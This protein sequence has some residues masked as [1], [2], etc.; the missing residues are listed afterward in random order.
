MAFG[1][2]VP[3]QHP[4]LAIPNRLAIGSFPRL[5]L[6]FFSSVQL[7]RFVATYVQPS[8]E[9][10]RLW[11]TA[12]FVVSFIV[13]VAFAIAEARRSSD[14][15]PSSGTTETRTVEGDVVAR[16]KIR[17]YIRSQ[18]R[19]RPHFISFALRLVTLLGANRKLKR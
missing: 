9:P 19:R 3:C 18:V 11:V 12:I 16:D 6:Q 1:E 15:P 8:L 17:R 7:R 2:Y 5:S 10:Y 13:A 14:L 4:P